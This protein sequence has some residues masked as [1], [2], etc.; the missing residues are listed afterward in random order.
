MKI[1]PMLNKR[2]NLSNAPLL[3]SEE[4]LI[5]G[6]FFLAIVLT[7]SLFFLALFFPIPDEDDSGLKVIFV[8]EAVL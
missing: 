4:L 2:N 7:I 8:Y 3:T 1:S 5:P 6:A